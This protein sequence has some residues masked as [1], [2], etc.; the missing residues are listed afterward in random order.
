[1]LSSVLKLERCTVHHVR[2]VVQ[3][4][5]TESPTGFET[6]AFHTPLDALSTIHFIHE[7]LSES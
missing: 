3:R 1:M 7:R 4:K 5:K 2:R 6:M